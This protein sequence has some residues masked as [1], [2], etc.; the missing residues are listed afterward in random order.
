MK[1]WLQGVLFLVLLFA[2]IQ[3]IHPKTTNPSLEPA[4]TINSTLAVE[5]E[6]AILL[7][8]SCH[9]CH[10]NNTAWPWYSQ[11]APASWLVA[12]DVN[13]GR[14]AMNLSEWAG[15]DAAKQRSLLTHIC[16]EVKD[17]EMPPQAYKV[18]HPRA[19]VTNADANTL[20]AWTNSTVELQ[21]RAEK[22]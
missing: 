20:C 8:R 16:A 12:N 9:D 11:V 14:R 2:V 1:T 19:K 15:I 17:G 3:I 7:E 18:V 6:V 21:R 4:K 13:R 10:S 22:E 5:G